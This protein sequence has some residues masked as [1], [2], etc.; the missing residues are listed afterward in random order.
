MK[1]LICID[2]TDN[3]ESRGTGSIAFEMTEIIEAEGWGSCGLISRHQLILHKD[4]RYTSHNSSMCFDAVVDVRHYSAMQAKLSRYI[5]DESAEDSDPG[6]CIAEVDRLL[7][8]EN[9]AVRDKLTDFAYKAKTEVLT[10]LDAYTLAEEAGLFLC[11]YGGTGDGVIG[12]L[13]G[14]GLRLHGY[15]GEVKGGIAH[16]GAGL[17]FTVARLREEALISEVCTTDMKPLGRDELV[18]ISW[19]AKPVLYAGRPVLLV[20]PVT[21]DRADSC[22]W[23]TMQKNEMRSFGDDRAV[24]KACE[25]FKPDVPEELVNEDRKTCFN[26][27]YRRWTEE[28]FECT[29]KK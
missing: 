15:D 11:E 10:K 6:L 19:K 20:I 5:E 26:C 8:P 16:L 23:Q 14:A 29:I 21:E 25:H 12:A 3:L 9:K 28:S 18:L 7:L 1:L 27:V 24:K 13:A 22:C 2:D 17:T 4:V